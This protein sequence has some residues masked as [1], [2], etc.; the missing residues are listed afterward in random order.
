MIVKRVG[1]FKACSMAFVLLFWGVSL[2]PSF[3]QSTSTNP[4]K[5]PA[6]HT[7]VNEVGPKWSDLNPEQKKV[8]EPLQNLWP[9]IE[10]YRKRKWLAI[11][12]NFPHMSPQA[13]ATAQERMREW[14]SLTPAQRYQARLH[15][16]QSQAYS[17]D[18]KIAKWEAYQALSDEEKNKLPSTKP[19]WFKGAALVSKPVPPEKLT[20][21][22]TASKEG[23][24]KPPRIETAEV[25]PN[26]LLPIKKRSSSE[27]P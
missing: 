23:Q 7:S 12:K 22:P 9:S 25:D 19:V 24:E 8:L 18:E 15:F 17:S 3:A 20:A 11:A 14:A 13:Q 5:P 21:T 10:D 27:K 2:S 6:T 1:F 4:K 26:T 16:A